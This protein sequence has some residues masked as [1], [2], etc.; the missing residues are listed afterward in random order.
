M[1]KVGMS[2]GA[3]GLLAGAVGGAGAGAGAGAAGTAMDQEQEKVP[4][5]RLK[6]NPD[7]PFEPGPV[8]SKVTWPIMS[9][10]DLESWSITVASMVS[11]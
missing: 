2:T 8:M 5:P 11:G 10:A 6:V 1:D 3:A 9:S 7:L 4:P